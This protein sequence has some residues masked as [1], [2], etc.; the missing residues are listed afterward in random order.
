ME[1]IPDT[2]KVAKNLD[3]IGHRPRGKP[4]TIIL[5]KEQSNKMTPNVSLNPYQRSFSQ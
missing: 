5:F 4:N 2:A 1:S 3:Y